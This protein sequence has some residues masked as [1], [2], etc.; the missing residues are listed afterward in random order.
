MGV[1]LSSPVTDKDSVDQAC[2]DFVYGA[3]SMQG[4]RITQ[5]DAHNCIPYFYDK[6][7]FFAVYDGHGGSEVAKYCEIHFPDLVKKLITENN[8]IGDDVKTFIQSAFLEFDATLTE[9]GVI[10]ELKELAG[11]DDDNDDEEEGDPVGRTETDMLK[12]EANMPL[13]Q[14]L[15]QYKSSPTD[16]IKNLNKKDFK[17]PFLTGPSKALKS[18]KNEDDNGEVSSLSVSSTSNTAKEGDAEASLPN[19]VE[20]SNN[21]NNQCSHVE[22][23]DNDSQKDSIVKNNNDPPSNESDNKEETETCSKSIPE[24]SSSGC[25]SSVQPGG[26]SSEAEGPSSSE[27]EPSG[28]GS[29][30]PGIRKSKAKAAAEMAMLDGDIET[31]DDDEDEDEE[32]MWEDMSDDDDDEEDDED[33]GQDEDVPMMDVSNEEPGS[34]SGCTACVCLLQEKKLIVANAGDSRC[35]LSRAGR[36]IELSFDHKPEDDVERRRIETAGGKVTSD[37]RV[38]G[39]LNL[40]RALGDHV[41]KRNKDLPDRDQMITALPDVEIA[42]LCEDDQFFVIACDGIW[43]YMSSQEV[44]DY[45][46]EKLKD[47]EKRLKPSL[48]CEE[49]FDHC[50]APNTF[51]DGTGCDNM[52]CIIVILNS[53]KPSDSVDGSPQAAADTVRS[54]E[55]DSEDESHGDSFT[56]SVRLWGLSF[57]LVLSKCSKFCPSLWF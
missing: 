52:T 47:P 31:S 5:E 37:G 21:S 55:K 13:D 32:E 22:S 43:N 38:N 14:L 27:A 2:T 50:L 11:K 30:C 35:V 17:S 57:S 8:G 41:Y 34:D 49:L 1:Y 53:F 54:A 24:V 16:D 28:S 19:G 29:S 36:A 4:W 33:E 15:A 20:N 42:E 3:S 51:G 26:S 12:E 25:G 9:D 40:S 18:L 7:S 23:V 46:L 56:N 44:V 48:I 39:G 45:V 10:K 6:T